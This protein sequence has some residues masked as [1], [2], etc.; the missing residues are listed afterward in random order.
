MSNYELVYI[1]NP[2]IREDGLSGVLDKVSDSIAKAG[3]N[4]TEVNQWGKKKL[5]YP[6]KR[7]TE[8][9]YVLTRLEI[10]P[11]AVYELDT[12]LRSSGDIMRHLLV[13]V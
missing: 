7:F 5:S 1:V 2:D 13:K 4:V 11:G 3:G 6:I 12:T 8:G 10:E 9:H